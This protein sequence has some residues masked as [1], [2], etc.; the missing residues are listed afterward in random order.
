MNQELSGQP[1]SRDCS[2]NEAF[3]YAGVV[4][5]P[6]GERTSSA[7]RAAGRH[8]NARRVLEVLRTDGPSS[9][10]S[11]A[12]RT[13]LSPATISNIVKNLRSQ[14]LA[15]IQPLN[16]R[17]SVVALVA[18]EGAVVAVQVNTTFVHAA[19][20]DYRRALR[21]DAVVRLDD[22]ADPGGSPQLVL[23]QIR[24]LTAEAELTLGE[25]AGVAVG[26]QGPLDRSGTVTSWARHQLPAWNNVA[27]QDALQDDLGVP[28]VV[29]NDAN[30]AAL[31]EWT[32]GTGRGYGQ[33]LYFMCSVGIGGG[34]MIDGNIY[35]GADGLAGEV[36]HLVVDQNGPVCFC[37]SRGC[38]TTFASERS[39][40]LALE[41]SGAPQNSLREVIDSARRGDP[42][43]RAILWEAG[44][45][46]GRAIANSVKLMAPGVVA[47]GGV[48]SEA[49]PLVFDSLNSSVEIDSLRAVSPSIR[50]EAAE[51]NADA[52]LFG[53]VAAV[54][55]RLG[56]GVS[57]L[58]DW[59]RAMV[60]R[61]SPRVPR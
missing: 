40:L 4:S 35:R 56:R 51:I 16:G 3:G 20:F 43:Y 18:N 15:D 24:Q 46:L 52:V 49:G 41:A 25:L 26:M 53:G 17:E 37:G 55:G 7:G 14:G 38:L 45:Y 29:D 12:R 1:K 31:A 9:Q 19:L 34:V 27:I 6:N 44:R 47:I 8:I 2:F 57:T 10:A 30:L 61:P 28:L 32:W 39:I 59:M 23:Q 21:R 33:F 42:A 48:L 60:G 50:I 36:G 58:P 11:L 54:L 5:T 13:E 22:G